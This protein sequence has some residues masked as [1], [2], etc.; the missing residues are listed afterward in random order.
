[1]AV[2]TQGRSDVNSF[3][4]FFYLSR[5]YDGQSFEEYTAEGGQRKVGNRV[6]VF[7]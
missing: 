7:D 5:S 6:E 1:M 3:V 4:T 2:A